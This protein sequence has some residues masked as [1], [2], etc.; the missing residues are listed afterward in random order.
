MQKKNIEAIYPLTPI[1]E[2]MLYHCIKSPNSG[3]YF[4][5][6]SCVLD[7]IDDQHKWQ[8]AWQKVAKK[9]PVIRTFFTWEKRTRPLQVVREHVELPWK[10]LDWRSQNESQI[11]QKWQE[12][13]QSDRSNPFDLAKA[14]LIHFTMAQTGDGRYL[15]LCSFHHIILDGWSQLL[16]LDD[17]LG[18]YRAAQ[19][20]PDKPALLTFKT[21]VEWQQSQD[22][23][24]SLE[25]WSDSLRGFN[26]P[27]NIPKDA[28]AGKTGSASQ[29]ITFGD[30]DYLSLKA[31]AR[32]NQVTLNAMLLGAMSILLSTESRTE[33]IVFGTTVAGRP[34]DM[35][36][37]DKTAGLFINTLPM[38]AQVSSEQILSVWLKTLQSAQTSVIQHAQTSLNEIQKVCEVSQ[39]VALFDTILVVE[40]LSISEND[41]Q[42]GPVVTH[43]HYDQFSHYPLAILVDPSDGLTLYALHQQQ[44]ISEQK[45]QQILALLQT[46]LVQMSQSLEQRICDLSLLAD[47]QQAQICGVV[48]KPG[49]ID[50]GFS[51]IHQAFEKWALTHPLRNAIIA[52]TESS[53]FSHSYQELN[54]Q[55]NQLA[56]Y[57][58]D[59]GCGQNSMVVV[60]LD[61]GVD[62]LVSFLAVLKTGAAYVP[63][64]P[65]H[66]AGRITSVLDEMNAQGNV[67]LTL[68]GNGL[69]IDQQWL[70]V[71]F[72]DRVK[73]QLTGLSQDNLKLSLQS[74]NLAYVIYTSGSTGKPK[75]VM[76]EHKALLHST[77][78]RETYYPHKPETFLLLSSLSTDSSIAGIYWTLC[79]GGTLVLPA[80]H[81]EQNMDN[82][83]NILEQNEVSHL[84]CIPGLYQLMLEH[85]RVSA[86]SK[87]NTVI[88]AGEA[89]TPSVVQHHQSQIPQ[90]RLYNE[91]G[92]SEYTV[93]TTVSDLSDWQQGHP[94]SIGKPISNTQLYVLNA[95]NLAVPKG[96]IGELYVGGAGL[97]RGYF[98]L[99]DKTAVSF[100]ENPYLKSSETDTPARLYRT[101][102][103]VRFNPDGNLEFIGRADNQIKIR[104]FR[105]EPEEVEAVLNQHPKVKGSV[106]FLKQDNFQSEDLDALAWQ[107]SQMN[108]NTVQK[109]FDE[110]KL[111]SDKNTGGAGL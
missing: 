24:R 56:H 52:H 36:G 85:C 76:I 95:D 81:M 23:S 107:L 50:E 40:N 15:F 33:D 86:L 9:H 53:N 63:L 20:T 93:W 3:F 103:L 97:A 75:G 68:S 10:I 17:A 29:S 13:K 83:S 82:L 18:F 92:P 65:A 1:Q 98:K 37:I 96:V 16:L 28:L 32:Q 90:T 106:V 4:Q 8:D 21:F 5:Q 110:V 11:E 71:C 104:G 57:L 105:V 91:Y 69:V 66:P 80:H 35:P 31:T 77:F 64:D 99:P 6:F 55:A 87:L 47:H 14:P 27:T 78:A 26:H 88:V 51:G 101:G 102:D 67:V 42:T 22:H 19:D 61:K 89:C 70:D 49:Y 72:I 2:G 38:R 54:V 109:L 100:V 59:K 45:A 34:V 48:E 44:Y 74:E 41:D 43:R 12:L 73:D 108:E 84:L 62:A 7:K 46:L 111:L 60:L 39:G 79:T 30:S 58:I 94:V 25:Y